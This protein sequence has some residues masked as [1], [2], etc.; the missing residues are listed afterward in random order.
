MVP[1]VGARCVPRQ[2][3]IAVGR[4]DGT[5]NDIHAV[6]SGGIS[7]HGDVLSSRHDAVVTVLVNAGTR[8]CTS[9]RNGTRSGLD[10]KSNVCASIRGV[11]AQPVQHN[12][13]CVGSDAI[14]RRSTIHDCQ[15]QADALHGNALECDVAFGAQSVGRA[16]ESDA[17]RNT[18]G[19][20]VVVGPA[21]GIPGHR[22]ITIETSDDL[23]R[24]PHQ[25]AVPVTGR[26]IHAGRSGIRINRDVVIRQDGRTGS[27]HAQASPI[28]VRACGGGVDGDGSTCG[29]CR[30]AVAGCYATTVEVNAVTTG[31][32]DR[33]VASS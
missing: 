10:R 5:C 26:A 28:R 3:D 22:Q 2:C 25:N 12:I 13:A 7:D 14:T 21:V 30:G 27:V 8:T 1:G 23:V 4:S 24:A 31:G 29:W 15:I 18:G 32:R 11:V 9:D 6:A 17:A 33:D 20:C 16:V 19:A